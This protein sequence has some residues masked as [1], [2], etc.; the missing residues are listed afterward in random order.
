MKALGS[1]ELVSDV[2]T[3]ELCI[4]CGGCVN[5]CPY[6]RSFDGVTSQLF[7]CTLEEGRCFAYCPKIEVDLDELSRALYGGPY[8]GD[9]LGS[10]L[11]IH[12]TRAGTSMPRGSFQSGGTVSA[13]VSFALKGSLIDAAILTDRE[14]LLPVPRTITDAADVLRCASSKYA[15]AP[16]V[17]EVNAALKNGH[18]A[19]GVVATPCQTLA[20]AQMRTAAR[21]AGE[22][23][24]GRLKLVIGLFC[25][26]ALDYRALESLLS[27]RVGIEAI[28]KVDIPPPPAELVLVYTAAGITEVPLSEVRESIPN[29]C[30]YCIDM[31]AEFAD[32]SVGVL[33]G[34]TGRNT[35]IVRTTAGKVL[36]EK[37][38]KSGYLE[39]EAYPKEAFEHLSWAASNK[40]RK[41]LLKLKNGDLLNTGEGA[42][43]ASIRMRPE[44]VERI[45]A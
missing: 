14:H 5:L 16:T 21:A 30:G 32:I 34:D 8:N 6:F 28:E 26:W 9:P 3:K 44:V 13:L 43:R 45:V 29:T 19:L 40:K 31:T 25:T 17:G 35:L 1:R 41:A 22:D 10:Y 2:I 12:V 7:P 24:A 37:A 42:Q 15:A 4:G 33:E 36:V 39:I 18:R 23:V 27:K 38:A 20:L 11:S